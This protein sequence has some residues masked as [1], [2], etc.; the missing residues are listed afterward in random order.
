MPGG[1]EPFLIGM[2]YKLDSCI[3]E[4]ERF[5]TWEAEVHKNFYS[6]SVHYEP[7]LS[8]ITTYGLC[9]CHASS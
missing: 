7:D 3:G 2:E 9:R 4:T 6:G 8:F 5:E 1:Y